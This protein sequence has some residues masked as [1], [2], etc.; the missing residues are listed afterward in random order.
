MMAKR[1]DLDALRVPKGSD[2]PA[3]NTA[4]TEGGAKGYAH[5]LSLRL[6]AEQ[7]RRLRR[8]VAD[9]EE[10]HGKRADHYRSSPGSVSD[11][12][13]WVSV[14][15]LKHM[16]TYRKLADFCGVGS[17]LFGLIAAGAWFWAATYWISARAPE[18]LMRSSKMTAAAAVITAVSVFLAAV[19][20]LLRQMDR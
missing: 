12:S 2:P 17:I 10:K 7:Y 20:R 1:P 3:G 11:Q 8:F 9:Q 19:A 14:D 13:R 18:L 15:A 5:T 6:T 16:H 4:P